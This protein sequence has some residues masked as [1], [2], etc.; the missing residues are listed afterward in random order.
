MADLFFG[1]PFRRLLY[2][3]PFPAE[4]ASATAAMDWIETPTSHVLRINVPGLGKDD[5]KVQVEDGNVLSVRST[6]PAEKEREREKEGKGAV[7]HVAERGRPEFAREVALP[8]DVRVEQIRASVDN[9]VLTVVVPKEPSP[10]RP[11]PRPI[12]VSSKL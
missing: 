9:G 10:A 6:P 1:G 5:V 8:A 2:G 4:W 7:W 12:A 3:R 11:R